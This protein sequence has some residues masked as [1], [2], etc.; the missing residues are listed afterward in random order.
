MEYTW[1]K[2]KGD[3]D[4]GAPHWVSC[5]DGESGVPSLINKRTQNGLTMKL[6][7]N[8]LRVKKKKKNPEWANCKSQEVQ[9]GGR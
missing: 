9:R 1:Q 7:N 6:E 2:S 4:R 5:V 3:S 8:M